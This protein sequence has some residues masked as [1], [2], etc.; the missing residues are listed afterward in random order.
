MLERNGSLALDPPQYSLPAESGAR[1]RAIPAET[2]NQWTHGLGLLLSL[3]AAGVMAQTLCGGRFDA[4][5]ACGCGVYLVSLVALYSASTL[6]HSFV[7]PRR[8]AFFRTLDQVCILMLIAGNYTA[9]ALVHL[10]EGWWWALHVAIWLLTAVGALVRVRRGDGSLPFAF[11]AVLGWLP[12][13]SLGRVLEL[14]GAGGLSLV[15]GG[16]IAYTGGLW[17]LVNDHRRPYL[18]AAWHLSTIAGST[19]H[20]LFV[21]WYVAQ[22]AGA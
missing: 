13:L 8:R 17:F 20:F 22:R 6:S 9:F 12:V 18:H 7:D 16:G 14:S 21:L 5:R 15:I 4:W 3:A 10:R 2:A 1:A 11:F 19:C